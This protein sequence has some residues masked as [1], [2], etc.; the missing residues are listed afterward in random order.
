MS[1]KECETCTGTG[2][3][4]N[5]RAVGPHNGGFDPCPNCTSANVINDHPEKKAAQARSTTFPSGVVMIC[6]DE[7]GRH[8]ANATDFAPDRPGGYTRRKVQEL[9]CMQR[10]VRAVIDAYA[11]PIIADCMVEWHRDELMR[12]IVRRGHAIHTIYIPE[13]DD[14]DA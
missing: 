7:R 10:L 2:S 11:N 6:V 9:R 3:V 5:H 1:E 12:E 14:D 13:G 8:I 4:E